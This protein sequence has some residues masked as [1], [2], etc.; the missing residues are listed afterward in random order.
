MKSLLQRLV[1]PISISATAV[2][3]SV[4][5]GVAP[6]WLAANAVVTAR[7]S[8]MRVVAEKERAKIDSQRAHGWDF[9]TIEMENLESE[10]KETKAQLQKQGDDVARRAEL[11]KLE[12]QEIDRSRANVETLR[13]EIDTQV[14][15]IRADEMKNLRA[16][17]LTYA[18]LSPKGAVAILRE[19]DDTTAVKILF[20]M[21]ADVV[22]PI[23]EEMTRTPSPD[24]T[25]ATRAA[26]LSERLRL[27]KS[28]Q[29]APAG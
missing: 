19:L 3:L 22:G 10:L 4:A 24:G 25:L 17:A 20:L 5:A 29:P 2:F 11:L 21:K 13:R 8:V 27:M 9:W 6:C 18:N 7:L 12:E 1:T 16:L 15:A 23:F 28:G 14:I 26:R